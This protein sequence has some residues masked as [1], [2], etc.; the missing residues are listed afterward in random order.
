MSSILKNAAAAAISRG[1][2]SSYYT[3][4]NRPN[5]VLQ[6][7]DQELKLFVAY[8]KKRSSTNYSK[9]NEESHSRP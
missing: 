8:M 1:M 9:P 7:L 4:E 5:P 6:A 2:P 3:K